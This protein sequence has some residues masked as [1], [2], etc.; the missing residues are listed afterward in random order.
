MD[1]ALH[2]LARLG[3]DD[4]VVAALLRVVPGVSEMPP[5]TRAVARLGDV[6]SCRLRRGAIRDVRLHESVASLKAP[7]PIAQESRLF[8]V[9]EVHPT[10]GPRRPSGVPETG[11]GVVVG[12]VDFGCDI[13][14]PNFQDE[15]GNTRLR[16]LWDQRVD[17]GAPDNPY[18]RG[19]I[20]TT[21]SIDRALRAADPFEALGYPL[22][23]YRGRGSH[24]SHVLDIAAGRPA[25]GPGGI[26]PGAD[27][28]FV[29]IGRDETDERDSFG[30]SVAVVEAVHFILESAGTQ[31]CVINLSMGR[32][33][34]PHD[35]STLVEQALD[36][37][38]LHRPGTAIVN[39]AGNYYR[40]RAH[41]SG[42]LRSGEQR[43]L[44]WLVKPH[45]KTG[46]E[47]EVWYPGTDQ[48]E[49]ELRSP[50]GVRLGPVRIGQSLALRI[51][52]REVGRAYHRARDPNNGDNHVDVFLDPGAPGGRWRVKIS[53][54]NAIDGRFDA[55]I[56]RDPGSPREQ[57]RFAK[58]DAD[59]S[60]TIGTIA[61]GRRTITV[62]A[63]DA[64][65]P[66]QR[67]GRFS[68]SG[69]TRD[70]R[71]KPELVAPGV[72]EQ[73]A[74]SRSD[75][76][77][78][79]TRKSGTSMAAPYV[80]GAVALMLEADPAV[81][82][83]RIRE[84]LLETTDPLGDD[85]SA[86]AGAGQ[87]NIERCLDRVRTRPCAD[88]RPSDSSPGT[89]SE[90][91]SDLQVSEGPE[92][93]PVNPS[94]RIQ[95]QDVHFLAFE[96][97]GGKG[98]ALI[99]AVQ[100]LEAEGILRFA[101]HRIAEGIYGVAGAS[102]GALTCV[103]VASGYDSRWLRSRMT[104]GLPNHVDFNRFMD[105]PIPLRAP[106]VGRDCRQ[107]DAG[108]LKAR[109]AALLQSGV[110]GILSP[111]PIPFMS[112]LTDGVSRAIANEIVDALI[113]IRAVQSRRG[114]IGKLTADPGAYLLNLFS[115]YGF[116]SGCGL[117]RFFDE[118]IAR[119]AARILGGSWQSHRHM[120][121]RDHRELFGVELALTG[122]NLSTGRSELF[123][124]R[125]SPLFP[126][127][128]AARIS[129]SLPFVYKPVRIDRT[130]ASRFGN[131][132]ASGT[133]I[134]N[135]HL[136]GYWV[137]GG[138]FNNIPLDAFD[139]QGGLGRT[140]GVR[141]REDGS[142]DRARIRSFPEFAL[143]YLANVALGSGE[144]RA[145]ETS[146]HAHRA[147]ELDVRELSTF[148]FAPSAQAIQNE[149]RRADV[150]T[151]RYFQGRRGP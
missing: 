88:T 5:G 52:G 24:G 149:I 39:S 61:N 42:A 78:G 23:D 58:H 93:I 16:A 83:H 75:S 139:A 110:R 85:L 131:P 40:R 35:G 45:D 117:R 7:R 132:S 147:V 47:L 101:D 30:D 114:L 69:P 144:S 62:G 8:D 86:R 134:S 4:D 108:R 6:V 17:D 53:S 41:A 84:V 109:V 64:A 68:S 135:T 118:L 46:N 99:G 56:E 87:L 50:G 15:N 38:V 67:L 151:R 2:E 79:L 145:S 106:Y 26:A 13:T 70:G 77:P 92:R 120:N 104:P 57:S 95:R 12:V 148:N 82:I 60:M 34:G 126:V 146:G 112:S 54:R 94:D 111:L 14:H 21:A 76:R 9:A 105:L 65:D 130:V 80:T 113:E 51:K 49:V 124:A 125:T 33:G 116:F 22:G 20:H 44:S 121:F 81:T 89:A 66:D 119:Q 123:S 63:Y 32:H 73:A 36:A 29:H 19:S 59:P 28:V 150:E 74:R 141:L 11:R 91:F 48:V 25:L 143:A 27:L 3:E 98:Y 18:E 103:A 115:G 37:A 90:D 71:T 31:P 128:D 136:Q 122:S 10:G 1:P 100:A 133:L 142:P 96:G 72:R 138:L 107:I 43:V 55:W 102:A 129:M 97:G 137:D 140:F 127:A